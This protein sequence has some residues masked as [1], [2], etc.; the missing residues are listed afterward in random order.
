[1]T[2]HDAGRGQSLMARL[3]PA[4]TAVSLPRHD[5]VLMPSTT[6]SSAGAGTTGS[7]DTALSRGATIFFDTILGLDTIVSPVARIAY[8]SIAADFSIAAVIIAFSGSVSRETGQPT[9][10]PSP[11]RT[12]VPAAQLSGQPRPGA[13]AMLRSS[14]PPTHLPPRP[15]ASRRAATATPMFSG[16]PRRSVPPR[17]RD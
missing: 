9:P 4:A 2:R 6:P 10:A 8:F 1:M 13:S 15:T 5:G 16:R 7:P 3:A 11:V 12:E 17:S 14:S